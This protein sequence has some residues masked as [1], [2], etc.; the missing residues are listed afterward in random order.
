MSLRA[1]APS[2]SSPRSAFLV[3]PA[4]FGVLRFKG[5]AQHILNALITATG[6]AFIDKRF[7]VGRDAQLHSGFSV[8]AIIVAF[9]PRFGG[10]V[11]RGQDDGVRH[12]SRWTLCETEVRPS[13]SEAICFSRA[14]RQ[15]VACAK[16][17]AL[18]SGRANS[19]RYAAQRLPSSPINLTGNARLGEVMRG[20][21]DVSFGE[22]WNI[23]ASLVV[24][25]S[26]A[27][28]RTMA[29][30]PMVYSSDGDFPRT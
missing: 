15:R 11:Q 22:V 26:S 9:L 2:I 24:P 7:K 5:A 23:L 4:F 12:V 30:L 28:R 14:R 1:C 10:G 27:I 8:L 13:Q 21:P 6:K 18:G 3:G 20:G 29:F 19:H 16:V 17:P 25:A